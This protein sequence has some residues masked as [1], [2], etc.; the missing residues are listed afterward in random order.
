MVRLGA[1]HL[2]VPHDLAGRWPGTWF[3]ADAEQ[4]KLDHPAGGTCDQIPQR[5]CRRERRADAD[6]SVV[7]LL[8]LMEQY[9]IRRGYPSC[10]SSASSA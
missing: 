6:G 5:A 4:R 7:D 10:K 1:L 3:G 2:T 8:K 9:R